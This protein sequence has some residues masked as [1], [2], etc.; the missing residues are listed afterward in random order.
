MNSD[1]WIKRINHFTDYLRFFVI[2]QMY[3]S[4]NKCLSDLEDIPA[5]SLNILM[6]TINKWRIIGIDQI[7][8]SLPERQQFGKDLAHVAL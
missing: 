5:V 3:V 2:E 8:V 7:K 1:E 4:Y 6:S